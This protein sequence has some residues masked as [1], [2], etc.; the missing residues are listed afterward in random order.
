[1]RDWCGEG[2]AGLDWWLLSELLLLWWLLGKLLLRLLSELLLRR[3][4]CD[5][6]W[7]RRLVNSLWGRSG[8]CLDFRWFCESTLRSV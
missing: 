4:L 3:L 2:G 8:D 6:W 1:M 5:Y 7:S